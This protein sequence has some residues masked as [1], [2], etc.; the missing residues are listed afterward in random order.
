VFRT[1][2]NKIEKALVA[3]GHIV[4]INSEKPRKGSFVV[5]IEG[6]LNPVVELLDM[7]R[8]FTDLKALNMDDLI[9]SIMT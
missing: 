6:Q 1:R 5:R 4:T 7:P 9:A 2:A 8:P 3:A